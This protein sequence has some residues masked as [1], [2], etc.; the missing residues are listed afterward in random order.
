MSDTQDSKTQTVR[1]SNTITLYRPACN[2]E[3]KESKPDNGPHTIII[4]AWFRALRKHIAKYIATYQLNH[5]DAQIILLESVVGDMMYTPYSWQRS[6]F[7]AVVDILKAVKASEEEGILLHIFSNGGSNSAVQLA[8]AWRE[9][10]ET[11]LPVASMV[12]DSCP[13]ST[14]LKLAGDA[15]VASC[16]P[17]SRWWAVI[18]VWTT[19]IPIYAIPQL[20]G[21]PNLVSIL[22]D[23]LNDSRLFPID[24]KRVYLASPADVMVPLADVVSHFESAKKAGYAAEL[25]QFDESPHVSH[26]KED[27]ERYWKAVGAVLA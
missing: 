25:V 17:E 23:S 10:Q 21:K 22:R 7:S 26:I 19:I 14:S 15:I 1:I 24:A 27:P 6:R 5:P 11:P 18:A 4:C 8:E 16:P 12:L 20:T 13:G 2:P 3:S 9:S